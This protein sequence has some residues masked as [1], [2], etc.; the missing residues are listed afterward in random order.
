MYKRYVKDDGVVTALFP[1]ESLSHSFIITAQFDAE[2]E[3]KENDN[4]RKLILIRK[5]RVLHF[6]DSSNPKAMKKIQHYVA[7]LDHRVAECDKADEMIDALML[8]F[9]RKK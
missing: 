5:E 3:K 1:F 6:A 7:E 4:V 2:K 8:P 9:P